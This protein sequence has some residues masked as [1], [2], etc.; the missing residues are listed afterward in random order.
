M[1]FHCTRGMQPLPSQE[2]KL[3]HGSEYHR[4]GSAAPRQGGSLREIAL[5]SRWRKALWSL[6]HPTDSEAKVRF[7][8]ESPVRTIKG[9]FDPVRMERASCTSRRESS[10]STRSPGPLMSI[11]RFFQFGA[12]FDSCVLNQGSRYQLSKGP[13]LPKN[14]KWLTNKPSQKLQTSAST[15]ENPA[16]RASRRGRVCS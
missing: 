10:R 3:L 12:N 16:S 1:R 8:L 9:R 2:K 14:G 6:V 4:H 13:D 7:I 5:A 15:L 11:Q